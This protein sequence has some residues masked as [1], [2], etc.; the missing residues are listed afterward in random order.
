MLRHPFYSLLCI[1]SAGYLAYAD[2]HGRSLWHS[3]NF[4]SG[5]GTSGVGRYGGTGFQHK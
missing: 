4:L 2:T 3:I 5:G 1:L